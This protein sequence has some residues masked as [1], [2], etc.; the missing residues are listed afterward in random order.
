MCYELGGL[1][2]TLPDRKIKWVTLIL[3]SVFFSIENCVFKNDPAVSLG[4]LFVLLA[5]FFLFTA[6]RYSGPLLLQHTQEFMYAVFGSIYLCFLP[7]ILI[8]VRDRDQ[9]LAWLLFYLFIIWSYDVGAY[10][11]GRRWGVHKLYPEISPKKTVEGSIGGILLSLVM[12]T[13]FQQFY[14]SLV[15]LV[16]ILS[17]A[18][19]ICVIA[20]IGDLIESQVKRAFDKKDSSLLLPGHGGFLDRF[21][22]VVFALPIMY[23]YLKVFH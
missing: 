18:L 7:W 3:S 9:G 23:T 20:Q 13:I 15:P 8:L 5:T 16:E 11:S 2:F 21:D 10:F 6:R 14:L 12:A 4:L 17:L 19:V 22:S 1:I